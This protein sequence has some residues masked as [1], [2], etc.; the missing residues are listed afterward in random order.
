MKRDKRGRPKNVVHHIPLGTSATFKRH[1]GKHGYVLIPVRLVKIGDVSTWV[2]EERTC[3]CPLG[4]E[5]GRLYIDGVKTY[6]EIEHADADL[7]AWRDIDDGA[8][9]ARRHAKTHKEFIRNY[10]GL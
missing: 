4:E 10:Y 3:S 2:D 7:Q 8:A 6:V 9:A 5:N 1:A